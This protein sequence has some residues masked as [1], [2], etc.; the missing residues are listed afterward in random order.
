MTKFVEPAGRNLHVSLRSCDKEVVNILESTPKKV[1]SKLEEMLKKLDMDIKIAIDYK[2][3]PQGYTWISVLSTSSS[4][5]HTTPEDLYIELHINSC[6]V[7]P[8]I[9][10]LIPTLKL[11]N[12][13]EFTV[14]YYAP[15]PIRTNQELTIP[16]D[17]IKELEA[18]GYYQLQLKSFKTKLMS[19]VYL[20]EFE[21]SS[22]KS[23]NVFETPTN[24]NT[25]NKEWYL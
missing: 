21:R 14:F 24:N 12:P 9:H 15:K 5:L 13:E 6:G 18:L 16:T 3:Q 17:I 2:F 19:Q 1:I 10:A 7:Q 22:R 25:P 8:P 20:L 11:F 23:S 4:D